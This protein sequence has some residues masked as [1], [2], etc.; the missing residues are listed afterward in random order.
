MTVT[1]GTRIFPQGLGPLYE[2][3]REATGRTE[4]PADDSAANH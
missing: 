4:F 3:L 2:K 1:S